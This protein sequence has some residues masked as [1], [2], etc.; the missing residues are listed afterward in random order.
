M[1]SLSASH[2]VNDSHENWITLLDIS[3][4]EVSEIMLWCQP[5][6]S[7]TPEEADLDVTSMLGLAGLLCRVLSVRCGGKTAA[8]IT[9]KIARRRPRQSRTRD[10]GH[11]RRSL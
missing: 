10:S 8:L 11:P 6:K 4:P 1:K 7:A 9:S 5:T 2:A 3:T